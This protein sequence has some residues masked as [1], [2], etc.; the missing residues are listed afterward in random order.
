M[1]LMP[2]EEV[3]I[4]TAQ[5]LLSA[6]T[7]GDQALRRAALE[8]ITAQPDAALALGQSGGWDVVDALVQLAYQP[9]RYSLWCAAVQALAAYDD[10]RA[11][12]VFR[13]LLHV[14]QREPILLL[15]AERL[16]REPLAERLALATALLDQDRSPAHARAAA[17]LLGEA[18]LEPRLARR[19]DLLLG[20]WQPRPEQCAEL[21]AELNGPL[22]F[23]VRAPCE[24]AGEPLFAAL[25][26]EW[27]SLAPEARHWLRR[28]GERDHA[29]L[30]AR[31]LPK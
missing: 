17:T 5:A 14:G 6:L 11:V 21:V 29:A 8:A 2:A 9:E 12:D 19:R 10:P 24:A 7:G 27:D 23:A 13:K 25:C 3:R 30:S 22:S 20:R 4:D 26:G 31:L 1:S 18:Q 16:A 28:W 15:A